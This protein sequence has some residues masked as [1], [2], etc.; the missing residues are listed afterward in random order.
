MESVDTVQAD[1]SGFDLVK[2]LFIRLTYTYR[3]FYQFFVRFLGD[4]IFLHSCRFVAWG[5]TLGCNF[6]RVHRNCNI[7]KQFYLILS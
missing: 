1:K 5:G 3:S 6:G 7:L 4:D 2:S